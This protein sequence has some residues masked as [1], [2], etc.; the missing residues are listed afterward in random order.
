VTTTRR[1]RSSTLVIERKRSRLSSRDVLTR[2]CDWEL[3][4]RERVSPL[5]RDERRLREAEG[6]DV[7]VA[8]RDRDGASNA[9]EPVARERLSPLLPDERR[10][11]DAGGFDVLVI[12]RDRTLVVEPLRFPTVA[13]DEVP[14]EPRIARDR[15][16]PLTPD[17]TL[18]VLPSDRDAR[19][20]KLRAPLRLVES[21]RAVRT[22]A[23]LEDSL[24]AVRTCRAPVLA[25]RKVDVPI[26]LS[27]RT[28]RA[29]ADNELAVMWSGP[30][31]TRRGEKSR[32]K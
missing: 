5:S 3:I 16:E 28:A 20:L 13:R 24:K 1:D 27:N 4:A 22:R 6:V 23:D 17:A 11:R 14:S 32:S 12:A 26:L 2:P 19:L 7:L 9:R 30:R 21:I 8:A 15:S 25:E 31:I 29:R 18:R 10:L